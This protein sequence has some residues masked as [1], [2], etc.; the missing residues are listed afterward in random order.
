[1]GLRKYKREIAR[2]AMR[3]AD[4]GNVNRKMSR[5][6]SEG[7]P[8][9]RA[10]LEE[11]RNAPKRNTRQAVKRKIRMVAHDGAAREKEE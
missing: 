6:N 7:L 4:V 8:F 2:Q 11:L 3:A 9:W 5:R 1:M 10:V